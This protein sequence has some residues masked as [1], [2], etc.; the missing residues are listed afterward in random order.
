[1]KLKIEIKITI[2]Y[3]L[4]GFTKQTTCIY[5]WYA[6]TIPLHPYSI[7]NRV[8]FF[9]GTVLVVTYTGI[10]PAINLY[11]EP[12]LSSNLYKFVTTY[13]YSN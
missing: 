10:S 11:L 5:F 6:L 4:P 13:A 2:P 7:T 3:S 1:M 8:V 12:G 9:C